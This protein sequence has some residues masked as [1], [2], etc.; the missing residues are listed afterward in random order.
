MASSLSPVTRMAGRLVARGP[1]LLVEVEAGDV[2]LEV[3]V[4]HDQVDPAPADRLQPFGGAAGRADLE[5]GPAEVH[6]LQAGDAGVVLDDQDQLATVERLGGPARP[7][8]LDPPLRG[9]LTTC[10]KRPR[11]LIASMNPSYSTGLVR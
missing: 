1:E 7:V 8:Q 3:L 11:R 6:L 9:T 5:A 4:E 2:A 10:R